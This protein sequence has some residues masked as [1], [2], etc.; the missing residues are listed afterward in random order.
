MVADARSRRAREPRTVARELRGHDH[1]ARALFIV[2]SRCRGST[3]R[4]SRPSRR[5]R[6]GLGGS[7]MAGAP[8]TAGGCG[9]QGTGVLDGAAGSGTGS[10]GRSSRRQQ[11]L[12]AEAAQG[13]TA[14]RARMSATC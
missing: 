8:A 13:T 10:R 3:S 9:R 2:P 4:S 7:S 11:V 5:A 12:S 1:P 14:D 6:Q